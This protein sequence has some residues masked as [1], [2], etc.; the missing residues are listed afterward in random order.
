MCHVSQR[1]NDGTPPEF[2]DYGLIALGVPR[3]PDIPANRD[4]RYFDLGLCGPL[5]TDFAG[6]EEYCGLFRT[7]TLRNVALRQTFFHNGVFHSLRQAVEFYVERET[8][9]GRLYAQ[10]ADGGV[11]KYDDLP[12]G[13]KA[14][15]NMDPPF[16]RHPGDKPALTPTEIDDVVA[17]LNTLTD[18]Y[19]PTKAP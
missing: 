9:P 3:N 13:A 15:V 19:R 10:R 4:P 5:R 6:R 12:E 1:G 2:T 17:F 16:D 8:D 14:N 7:P 11:D 18:G